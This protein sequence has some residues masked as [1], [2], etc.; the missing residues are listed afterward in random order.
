MIQS[1]DLMMCCLAVPSPAMKLW[2][3]LRFEAVG[4]LRR[5]LPSRSTSALL[6]L[7]TMFV[8]PLPRILLWWLAKSSSRRPRESL[9]QLQ[10]VK[11]NWKNWK[12]E[13]LEYPG[14]KKEKKK[15]LQPGTRVSWYSEILPVHKPLDLFHRLLT[16]WFHPNTDKPGWIYRP[17]AAP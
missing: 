8:P 10:N 9:A 6:S 11:E 3:S 16:F 15:S 1:A 7:S 17:P 13:I 4:I 2:R 12:T 14:R 5:S